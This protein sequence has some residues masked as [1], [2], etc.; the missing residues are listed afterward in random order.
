[1]NASAATSKANITI[2]NWAQ[3]NDA[4]HDEEDSKRTIILLDEATLASELA[5]GT[6][7]LRETLGIGDSVP[8]LQGNS[9]TG[10]GVGPA[11]RTALKMALTAMQSGD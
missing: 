8:V 1:M 3:L 10:E 5:W 11:F 6:E 4:R 7:D 9:A 2:D